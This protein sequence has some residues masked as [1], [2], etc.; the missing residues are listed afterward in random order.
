MTPERWE[1]ISAVL[2]RALERPLEE[3]EAFIAEACG[4]DAQLRAE[5]AALLEKQGA[6]QAYFGELA[7]DL[8][9]AKEPPGAR[10]R[11]EGTEV[12]PYRL[13]QELG[14][15]GMGVV[16][17]ATRSD[18][19]F[20]QEVALKLLP[21]GVSDEQ[22][23][24]FEAERQILA[25]LQHPNTARLLDGGLAA[26]GTPYFVMDYVEGVPI[27][28]YC[29]EQ[30]LTLAQRLGLFRQVCSA[31][32]Y[33][34]RNLIVHRDLK[35]SNI[36]VTAQGDVKLLDFGIAKMVDP[37]VTRMAPVTQTGLRLMTPEYASPEQIRGEAI[38]TA[39]DVYQLGVLLYELLAGRRPY[40]L[41]ER[42]LREMERIILEEEP[43]R[44]STGLTDVAA[45]DDPAT[46]SIA[47]SAAR[48]TVPQRLRRDLEGDL[49]QIVLMALQKD[50]D[51]RYSSVEALAQ[52]VSRHLQGLPVLA[53]SDR[54][55]Y[56]AAKFLR[57][58][59]VI[60]GTVGLTF[61]GLAVGLG[62]A[63]WQGQIAAR[64]RDRARQQERLASEVSGFMKDMFFHFTSALPDDYSPSPL[65]MLRQ[66]SMHAEQLTSDDEELAGAMLY[67]IADLYLWAGAYPQADEL[68]ERVQALT[69]TPRRQMMVLERLATNARLQNDMARA[70]PLYD[71]AV[72]LGEQH[73]APDD[74]DLA[75]VLNTYA[76][77]LVRKAD[78]ER[79]EALF[80][81]I[82]AIREQTPLTQHPDRAL[83]AVALDNHGNALRKLGRLREALEAHE[84]SYAHRK[85]IAAD[86]AGE[87]SDT[88]FSLYH[89]TVAYW[90]LDQSEQ[91]MASAGQLIAE[92]E[93][94][95]GTTHRLAVGGRRL[96][97]ALLIKRGAFSDAGALVER[98][99]SDNTASPYPDEEETYQLTLLRA[100]IARETGNVAQAEALLTGLWT[101]LEPR[102]RDEG[103]SVL[104]GPVALAMGQTQ[105]AGGGP[106][107]EAQRWLRLG[108]E[109]EQASFAPGH[110]RIGVARLIL[111]EHQSDESAARAYAQAALE[112]F[113]AALGPEHRWARRARAVLTPGG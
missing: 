87:S 111:A 40:R 19:S 17:R 52:D 105:I 36:L 35:P 34:H 89:L 42:A 82:L 61:A 15:G 108:L 99:W 33:A 51:R 90:L 68:F 109:I 84:A 55:T 94:A 10:R 3:R 53:Q 26:D 45:H 30:R 11:L 103:R 64:E 20:E 50:T 49:D 6:A 9:P 25:P 41:G 44:P 86:M 102:W 37:S 101:E 56:R 100:R 83:M 72:A 76:V 29:D 73:L 28:A 16:Y 63:L 2:T 5:V 104:A 81:R 80:R 107:E 59:R 93:R 97:A 32:Q 70:M 23:Q 31:V 96:K 4:D 79:A 60:V 12:G 65:E 106:V 95:F 47:I 78:Y 85:I 58:H 21:M 112:D 1:K 43:T 54:W 46:S 62:A 88:P 14:R 91:A 98:A 27:T 24:R 13:A 110:Y 75:F 113:Q 22:F 92:G 48:A 38:T 7:D 69:R 57:R 71:R 8:A 18:G 39:S 67:E 77:A 74:T 66:G